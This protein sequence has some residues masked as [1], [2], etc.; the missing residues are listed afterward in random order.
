MIV[1]AAA[2]KVI[3]K[4]EVTVRAAIDCSFAQAIGRGAAVLAAEFA[5]IERILAGRHRYD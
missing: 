2:I 4:M 5:V 3:E 1:V